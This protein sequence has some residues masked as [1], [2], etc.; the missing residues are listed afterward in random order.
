MNDYRFVTS[1]FGEKHIGM[2]LVNLYSIKKNTKSAPV[3][4]FWQEINEDIIKDF[5]KAFPNVD[6][7]KTDFDISSSKIKRISSKTLVWEY[8]SN[9]IKDQNICFL[10][11]DMFVLK[12]IKNFFDKDFDILFTDKDK[13]LFPLNTGVILSKG[14]NIRFFFSKWLEVTL[15]II[16]SKD[17]LKQALSTNYPFGGADQM[18]FYNLVNYNRNKKEYNIVIENKEIKALAVPCSVLNETKSRVI[19]ENT[20]IVHYKGGWQMIL[21]N[22]RGFTKNR[23]KKDSWSM[24]MLYLKSYI[25]SISYLNSMTGK[26]YNTESFGINIPFYLD[27]NTLKENKFLYGI[28]YFISFIRQIYDSILFRIKP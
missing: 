15:K 17:L 25:D 4:V 6:F 20:Y 7:F 5:K 12:D 2:L 16:N 24:Y 9:K 14:E 1:V 26:K 19:D 10:D 28:F 21:L 22:G 13:E 23:T 3:F 18:A 11:A 8:A 27:K